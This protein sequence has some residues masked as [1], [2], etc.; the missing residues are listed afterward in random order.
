MKYTTEINYAEFENGLATKAGW[1]T[2]YRY[3]PLTREFIGADFDNVPY[4]G[5]I[6]GDS[7]LDKPTLP[8]IQDVAIVRSL[9]D[10]EWLVIAD[11]RGK[12]AYHTETQQRI[13]IDFIGELPLDLTLLEPKTEFDKWNGKKWMTDTEAQKA[14]LVAQV[15]QEKTQRLDEANNTIMYLQDAIEIGLDDDDYEAK[16]KAWKT[17]RVYLNRI[18]ASLSPD[19]SWPEKPQ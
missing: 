13:D 10:K 14:A 3:H 6:I 5:G 12:V 2:V 19:I 18:D 9:D 4:G 1:A 15:E 11:N 8:E 16:L 7:C 17:Y